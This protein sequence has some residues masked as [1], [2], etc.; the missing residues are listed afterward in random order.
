MS[1]QSWGLAFSGPVPS[2]GMDEFTKPRRQEEEVVAV[3]SNLNK[4][5]KSLV[6]GGGIK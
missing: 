6:I 2:L 1:P 3:A 4:Q 5:T